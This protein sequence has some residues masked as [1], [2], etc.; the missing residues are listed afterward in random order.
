MSV[1]R[2]QAIYDVAEKHDLIIIEDDPYYF[3]Q[4]NVPPPSN[5]PFDPSP[6]IAALP[7]SFLS[8]DSSGRVIRLDSF[9]K[10]LA[11]GLRAGWVTAPTEVIER[12]NSYY[13]VTTVGVSGPTQLMLYSLLE[14]KWGHA[15]FLEWL[16]GLAGE[17]GR[18]LD[19]VLKAAGACLP[20]KVCSWARPG[21]GMFLW[22]EVDVGKHPRF[23]VKGVEKK[24]VGDFIGDSAAE[25]VEDRI[26]TKAMKHGVQVTRGSL[27]QSGGA[28]DSEL[29]FRLTYAAAE[30]SELAEGVMKLAAAVR[31]EFGLAAT[32]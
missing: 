15:G 29:H 21:C 4:A 14:V 8:I 22:V 18:R 32:E 28:V 24:A 19:V 1:K 31:E 20:K 17:Y 13:E 16:Q 23:R 25:G 30:E 12:F 6:F 27:F 5:Q 7:S 26:W 2:K 3:L 9:S 10:V 11:P